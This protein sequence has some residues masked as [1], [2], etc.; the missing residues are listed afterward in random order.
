MT[1]RR[2]ACGLLLA[3]A[4]L[5]AAC[6]S[7]DEITYVDGGPLADGALPSGG[8]RGADAAAGGAAGTA[9]RAGAG[10]ARDAGRDARPPETGDAATHGRDASMDASLVSPDAA[11]AASA[12]SG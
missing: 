1:V 4:G 2:I 6:S 11:D 12:D 3:G 10:G 9:G 7:S 5:S 8:R